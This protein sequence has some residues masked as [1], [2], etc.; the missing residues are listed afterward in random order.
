MSQELLFSKY[1]VFGVIQSHTEALK[2]KI[3]GIDPA[4]LLN[5]SEQDLVDALLDEFRL[6]VPIIRDADL[7]IAHSGE[8][9]VDVSR[10]PMRLMLDPSRPFYIAGNKIVIAVPFD[11]DPEFF[12]IQPQ[13]YA[14]NPPRGEIVNNEIHLTYVSTNQKAEAI[15]QQY[16]AALHCDPT[17]SSLVTRVGVTV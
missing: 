11:G 6:N 4:V 10:D 5:A 9:Q 1:S 14:L 15:K 13:N 16:E 8:T 12:R 7:Y 17:K 2:K 3:Q